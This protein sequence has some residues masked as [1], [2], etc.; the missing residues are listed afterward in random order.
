MYN[1][2]YSSQRA[3]RHHRRGLRLDEAGSGHADQH[4]ANNAPDDGAPD[5]GAP[6]DD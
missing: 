1:T 2:A 4:P 6:D 3:G 5:D